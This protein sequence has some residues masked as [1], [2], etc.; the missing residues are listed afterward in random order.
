MSV[1]ILATRPDFEWWYLLPSFG[2]WGGGHAIII[3]I[4]R[5]QIS[6]ETAALK[7]RLERDK[8][9][10]EYERKIR[11]S[12]TERHAG[13]LVLLFFV[14]VFGVGWLAMYGTEGVREWLGLLGCW[15]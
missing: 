7:D 4:G 1:T 2:L 13:A 11:Y 8:M 10:H 15:C 3:R 9:R 6:P 5:R 14:V 12:W